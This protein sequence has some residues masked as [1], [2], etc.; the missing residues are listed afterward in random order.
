MKKLPIIFLICILTACSK[1]VVQKSPNELL[2]A[3][4]N[5]S[6]NM[7]ISY[8]SNKNVTE[9]TANQSYYSNGKYSMEFLDKE[10]LKINYENSILNITSGLT[11]IPIEFINYQ[12]LNKNPLF[13]SYFINIYFNTEEQSNITIDDSSIHIILPNNNEYLHSAKLLFKDNK[14][15]TL[16]YFDANGNVKVNIIYNEFTLIA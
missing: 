10:N 9:Y 3:I 2:L 14:P 1:N 6:C 16:T 11:T 4:K 12:E 15:Y 7:E 8:F 5:Y 13:L